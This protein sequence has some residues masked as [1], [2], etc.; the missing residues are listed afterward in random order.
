MSRGASKTNKAALR[1][2]DR[3]PPGH[4]GLS[5]ARNPKLYLFT[6]IFL[7]P[8]D[9]C[10]EHPRDYTGCTNHASAS[11]ETVPESGR[12]RRR[13]AANRRFSSRQQRK[14][15]SQPQQQHNPRIN[16]EVSSTS[17]AATEDKRKRGDDAGEPGDGIKRQMI[18]LAICGRPAVAPPSYQEQQVLIGSE[19]QTSKAE[20]SE[21]HEPSSSPT[22]NQGTS[23][24]AIQ[25]MGYWSDDPFSFL[26]HSTKL[27]FRQ[28]LSHV[29]SILPNE[30]SQ[31]SP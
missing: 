26:L 21:S 24:D 7:T 11:A 6:Y 20:L 10:H 3:S 27:Y 30:T 17:Q 4:Q 28:L 8:P 9:M 1:F 31:T 2:R 13:W 29:I 12:S 19:A 14:S 22:E 18:T 15:C 25:M 23:R 16:L 5:L